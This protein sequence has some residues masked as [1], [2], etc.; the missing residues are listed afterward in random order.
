LDEGAPHKTRD[1]ETNIEERGE[2]PRRYWHR[3]K[4]LEYKSNG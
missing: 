4:I 3:G 1:I 2:K